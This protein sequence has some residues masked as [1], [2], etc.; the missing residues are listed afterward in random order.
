[1]ALDM[2]ATAPALFLAH[3]FTDGYYSFIAGV[4]ESSSFKPGTLSGDDV[5][6]IAYELGSSWKM[7]GRVLNV[8]DAVIDQIE[9]DECKVFDRCY[10]KCNCVVFVIM[11]G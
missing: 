9:G 1:M 2:T 8:P 6:L 3:L 10:S 4:D 5:L 11:I 7:V